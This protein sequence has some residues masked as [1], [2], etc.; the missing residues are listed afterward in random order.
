MLYF[1]THFALFNFVMEN[2][3][4]TALFLKLNNIFIA[5]YIINLLLVH[6]LFIIY[7]YII[8]IIK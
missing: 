7:I 2:N 6:K 3:H 4:S 5:L 8:Y 1:Y